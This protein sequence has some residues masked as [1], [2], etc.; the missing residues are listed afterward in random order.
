MAEK[1]KHRTDG[2][3]RKQTENDRFKPNS[4]ENQITI[5]RLNTTHTKGRHNQIGLRKSKT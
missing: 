1:E 2:T 3:N 5:N 4:N